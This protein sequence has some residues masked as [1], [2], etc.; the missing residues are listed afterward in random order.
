MF[1][2]L[3][4]Q[5]FEHINILL[6]FNF[7]SI[8]FKKKFDFFLEENS[9]IYREFLRFS[10]AKRMLAEFLNAR[11]LARLLP[12]GTKKARLQKRKRASF[13]AQA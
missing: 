1:I 13:N 9:F 12:C 5:T 10:V 8:G 11:N 6:F 3:F 4:V 7:L 2:S